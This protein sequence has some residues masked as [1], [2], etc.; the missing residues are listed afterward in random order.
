[1]GKKERRGEERRRVDTITKNHIQVRHFAAGMFP[2]GPAGR[3]TSTPLIKW[4]LN[5]STPSQY[6]Q[7]IYHTHT[8]AHT[9]IYRR[10]AP[11]QITNQI[12]FIL[13]VRKSLLH[14]RK[15]FLSLNWAVTKAAFTTRSDI[16][17]TI[18]AFFRSGFSEA[19]TVWIKRSGHF[20][21]SFPFTPDNHSH[22]SEFQALEGAKCPQTDTF[23]WNWVYQI[24]SAS[25]ASVD[26]LSGVSLLKPNHFEWHNHRWPF[27]SHTCECSCCCVFV[28]TE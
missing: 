6:T 10:Q 17:T 14:V 24:S 9:C 16:Q 12:H 7:C 4:W 2:F 15:Y 20:S 23:T 28:K 21:N 26:L 8:H 27:D 3:L 22:I 5:F 13:P 19:H 18:A 25:V 1:M 11:S